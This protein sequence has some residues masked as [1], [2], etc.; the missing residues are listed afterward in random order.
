MEKYKKPEVK[1]DDEGW[2]DDDVYS[3]KA[4]LALVEDDEISSA[5][6]GF[7]EGYEE[8]C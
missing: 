7:M 6:D 3:N 8:A 1:D 2:V 4:R 5:E